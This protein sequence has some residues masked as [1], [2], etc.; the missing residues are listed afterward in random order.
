MK[1]T[2]AEQQ[3][4]ADD[5]AILRRF[6]PWAVIR[7]LSSDQADANLMVRFGRHPH[8]PFG[9]TPVATAVPVSLATCGLPLEDFS[10]ILAEREQEARDR[11]NA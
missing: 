7:Y 6:S 11:G 1:L 5:A 4:T 3:I 10:A 9:G 8:R 2:Y